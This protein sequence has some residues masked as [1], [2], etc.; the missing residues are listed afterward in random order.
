MRISPINNNN[1]SFGVKLPKNDMNSLVTTALRNDSK[2]GIPKLY[3]LLNRLDKLPGKKAEIKEI[4]PISRVNS[5]SALI[6]Y[7]SKPSHICQFRVDGEL[8][9]EGSDA[10]QTLCEAVDFLEWKE[11][12]EKTPQDLEQFFRE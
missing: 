12:A 6:G 5:Q 10:Y 11:N 2:D 8:I 3:T 9:K 4:W 7:I 1:P